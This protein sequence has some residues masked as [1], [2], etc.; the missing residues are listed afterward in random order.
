MPMNEQ[1]MSISVLDVYL[2]LF[3]K[4]EIHVPTKPSRPSIAFHES[5][6]CTFPPGAPHNIKP[7]ST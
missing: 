2:V 5:L 1:L 4:H 7:K 6:D 3:L